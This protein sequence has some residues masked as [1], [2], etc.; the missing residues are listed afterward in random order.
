MNPGKMD[1]RITIQSAT[2]VAD[3]YG[4]P[5]KTWADI[6][7]HPNVWAEVIP[8]RQGEQFESKQTNATV[9]TTFRIRWR[10][11]LDEAMRVLY[12]STPYDIH[13]IQEIRR[14]EGL[15]LMTSARIQ[16]AV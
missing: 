9:D 15:E 11:D 14:Q 1:R 7:T 4:Q 3:V 5:V 8:L 6:A 12:A 10:T 16:E 13:G 2:E